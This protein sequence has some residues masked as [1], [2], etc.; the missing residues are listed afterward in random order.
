MKDFT[1]FMAVP[2]IYSKL[3]EIYD[4]STSEQQQLMRNSC[5]KFRLMVSGS[6][7]LPV[8]TL[9]RWEQISKHV[10]LERYGMTGT[11]ETNVKEMVIK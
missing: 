2:T 10:L 4:E 1:L 7:S 6:M 5:N 3:I 11:T 9:H 8:S